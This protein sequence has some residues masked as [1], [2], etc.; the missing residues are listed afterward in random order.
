MAERSRK[1]RGARARA[2][3]RVA[4]PGLAA[5]AE[6]RSSIMQ[7]HRGGRRCRARTAALDP[8]R[9][10]RSRARISPRWSS[11]SRTISACSRKSTRSPTPRTRAARW[12]SPWCNPMSLALL[13][14]PGRWGARG[15]DIACGDGQPLGVPMSSGGPYFG[16][17]ACKKDIVR[18][19]P[20]RIVGRT[21]DLDGRDRL[22]ADPAG[23]RAA[24]PP[25]QGDFEH[26]HQPG[27]AGHGRHHL[28]GDH[29]PGGTAPRRRRVGGEPGRA[30]RAPGKD[31]RRARALPGRGA[32]P[33][34]RLRA[35]GGRAAGDREARR[36]R[37]SSPASA[38]GADYAGMEK[39][40]LLCTT[41][42]KT[43][44]TSSL[45]ERARGRARLIGARS[46]SPRTA[47]ARKKSA[48]F[49]KSAI[50]TADFRRRS[51]IAP[52]LRFSSAAR[53]RSRAAFARARA[54]PRKRES[55]LR[56]ANNAIFFRRA[57]FSRAPDGAID[58]R[59]SA[60][61]RRRRRRRRPENIFAKWLT[62]KNHVISF[63]PADT[64]CGRR[65]ITNRA[66]N[67]QHHRSTSARKVCNGG[68]RAR[69][70]PKNEIY[71]IQQNPEFRRPDQR[72]S[73]RFHERRAHAADKSAARA[74][75]RR[76]AAGILPAAVPL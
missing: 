29:R 75:A 7:E 24:H 73:G 41:E 6:A 21:T 52:R 64:Y 23:A 8:A 69:F 17:L 18:N 70:P 5:H 4:A 3:A 33:R 46:A 55:H 1:K 22:H 76:C 42:T 26:L 62:S 51:A 61:A 15:A 12:R 9:W 25:R 14:A 28:H 65:V 10:R 44:P 60:I 50:A 67:S 2:G 38:L 59:R 56:P 30:A 43:P 63:R 16:F 13:K 74:C 37:A 68:H 54:A 53:P 40:L 34:S 31:P 49:A 27:P 71:T 72:W 36:R 58:A 57:K 48:H 32:F 39:V 11:R 20:G 66:N 19:M 47:R 35:A 45:R